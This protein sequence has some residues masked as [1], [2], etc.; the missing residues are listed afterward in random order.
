MCALLL[1]MILLY[2]LW[3]V[4]LGKEFSQYLAL[5]VFLLTFASLLLNGFK[6]GILTLIIEIQRPSLYGNAKKKCYKKKVNLLYVPVIIICIALSCFVKISPLLIGL[7]LILISFVAILAFF[8]QRY[9]DQMQLELMTYNTAS[10]EAK[11]TRIDDHDYT[12][13][14]QKATLTLK[15]KSITSIHTDLYE[16]KKKCLDTLA[17]LAIKFKEPSKDEISHLMGLNHVIRLDFIDHYDKRIIELV[18][19]NKLYEGILD[20]YLLKLYKCNLHEDKRNRTEQFILLIAEQLPDFFE[21]H[22]FKYFREDNKMWI[23]YQRNDFYK[24]LPESCA[25]NRCICIMQ[26]RLSKDIQ[27]AI[28]K[29]D[30]QGFSALISTNNYHSIDDFALIDICKNYEGL[31]ITYDVTDKTIIRFK[32]SAITD[33][34]DAI[35]T[36]FKLYKDFGGE[37]KPLKELFVKQAKQVN[38]LYDKKSLTGGRDRVK[39][40]F[41]A[42]KF[43]KNLIFDIKRKFSYLR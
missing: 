28:N 32:E 5:N 9:K 10:T 2:L 26:K 34:M 21:R 23:R 15:F 43:H 16:A 8:E 38:D 22:I 6:L 31:P 7:F 39:K 27:D 30:I 36:I 24:R 13:A 12:R 17:N 42:P 37:T 3:E 25:K 4:S 14:M 19:G 40:A 1:G 41:F 33:D 11:L 18:K 35:N 29:G 20:G